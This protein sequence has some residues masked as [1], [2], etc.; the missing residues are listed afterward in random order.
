[1]TEPAGTVVLD[2]VVTVPT[3]KPA[4]VMAD[5]AA[6]CDRLTTLGTVTSGERTA[7][8]IIFHDSK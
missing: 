8:G 1:M 7:L 6:A 4:P 2:A 5:V 3:V